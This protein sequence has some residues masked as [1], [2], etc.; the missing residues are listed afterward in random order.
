[1]ST[2]VKVV[3]WVVGGVGA[4]VLLG[5]G[6]LWWGLSGGWDGI[7]PAAQPDDRDVVDAREAGHEPLAAL[8]HP[9]A[10]ALA[11]IG[12]DLGREQVDQCSSGQNN[13]KIKDG[14]T[15]SCSQAWVIGTTTRATSADAA[16]AEVDAAVRALGWVPASYGELEVY[17]SGANASGRYEHPDD[18]GAVLAVDVVA[19]GGADPYVSL[20]EFGPEYEEGDASPVVDAVSASRSVAVLA[21]VERTYFEDD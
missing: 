7:R 19:P 15:L 14:Y 21:V 12:A 13:W 11:E 20:G 16:A 18:Q 17:A 9:T 10:A 4:L 3:L 2:A 5:V 8:A 1:M 6:V